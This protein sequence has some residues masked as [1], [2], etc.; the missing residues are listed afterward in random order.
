M[1]FA[2]PGYRAGGRWSERVGPTGSAQKDRIGFVFLFELIFNAKTIPEILESI[3]KARK[4][5]SKITKI[6]G[7]FPELDWSMN[8]PNKVF[9]T[10]EKRFLSLIIN[11]NSS[12]K[13]RINSRKVRKIL[14]R[15]WIA[16]KSIFETFCTQETP[17][18]ISMNATLTTLI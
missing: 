17:R 8:N 4:N 2:G 14:G 3:L 12:R 5:T 16:P 13:M 7:K 15:I 6:P 10:H 18:C 9:G 1:G 11:R